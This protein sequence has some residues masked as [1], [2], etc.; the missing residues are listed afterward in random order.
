MMSRT[1]YGLSGQGHGGI[2]QAVPI[3]ADDQQVGE[4]RFVEMMNVTTRVAHEGVHDDAP[5][6]PPP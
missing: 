1:T 5:E 3:P 4:P 2:H 6:C